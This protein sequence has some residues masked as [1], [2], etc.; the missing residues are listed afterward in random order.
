MDDLP[1]A[2]GPVGIGG[3]DLDMEHCLGV[4][5]VGDDLVSAV[6]HAANGVVL[7][8]EE[9]EGEEIVLWWMRRKVKDGLGKEREEATAAAAAAAAA[10]AKAKG[11]LTRAILGWRGALPA[12]VDEEEEDEAAVA[13]EEDD[14]DEA[15]A[16]AAAAAAE[17][18]EDDAD[19][20]ADGGWGMAE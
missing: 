2:L 15:A 8:A 20:A 11:K 13:E 1:V 14:A 9:F 12:A 3:V 18:E 10:A 19:M 16:V 6:V 17:E 4:V 5:E 7:L